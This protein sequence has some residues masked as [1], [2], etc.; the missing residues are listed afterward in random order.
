M[1]RTRTTEEQA[2]RRGI[3]RTATLLA[4]LALGF[5]IAF[6]LVTAASN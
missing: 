1:T 6:I 2:R 3:I 5:Y 4:L